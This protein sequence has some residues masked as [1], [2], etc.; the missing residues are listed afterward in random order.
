M[1]VVNFLMSV[2]STITT[3]IRRVRRSA[4]P[5]PNHQHFYQ[6]GFMA[7]EIKALQS[8]FHSDDVES[9]KKKR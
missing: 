6:H 9:S 2:V 4:K 5:K 7:D 3:P 1:P 8:I